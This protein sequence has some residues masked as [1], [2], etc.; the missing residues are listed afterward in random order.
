M[1]IAFLYGG[2]GSQVEGMGWD[3]YEEYPIAKKYYDEIDLDFP[4]KDIS[5]KGSKELIDKTEYTQSIM[6]AFQIAV[7]KILESNNITPSITAGL[8]L[9]E[10]SALYPSNV[11]EAKEL[12]EL[13]RYRSLKMERV[14]EKIDSSMIAVFSDD[15]DYLENLCLSIS[16]KEKFIEVTN[17]NTRSQ[18]VISGDEHKIEEA[19]KKLEEDKTRYIQLNTS[20]PF[21]TAYMDGVSEDLYKYLSNMELKEAS[22]PIIHNLYGEIVEDT[23]MK[24]TLSEQVSNKVL[25]KK[26]LEN[27]LK[28]DLDL[29]VE[30]GYG[31]VIKGFVRRLDRKAEVISVNSV[32]SL[33]ELIQEVESLYG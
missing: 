32:E 29:I 17:I 27:I 7:T 22:I 8:S 4:L 10:F 3:L 11:L 18:I 20:G 23:D 5:F 26:T 9:G 13:V 33:E 25:F 6:V 2:Q 24:K 28:E 12:L 1:K 31:N 21:H 14:S 16:N 19:K 15:L 30:I